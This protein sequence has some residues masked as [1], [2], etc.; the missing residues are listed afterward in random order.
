MRLDTLRTTTDNDA[1]VNTH[2]YQLDAVKR[3]TQETKPCFTHHKAHPMPLDFM[4]GVESGPIIPSLTKYHNN[5]SDRRV[6]R[7]HYYPDC[8]Q[9][10]TLGPSHLVAVINYR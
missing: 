1:H 4:Q 6:R 7:V 2:K 8:R 9:R 5:P 10:T 3:T